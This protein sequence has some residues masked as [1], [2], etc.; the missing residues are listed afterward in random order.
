MEQR[1][2]YALPRY[3]A[4]TVTRQLVGHLYRYMPFAVDVHRLF[5]TERFRAHGQPQGIDLVAVARHARRAGRLFLV[6]DLMLLVCLAPFVA[7][8]V[9]GFMAFLT[10]DGAR[11]GRS[12]LLV[13]GALAAG[14]LVVF[15]WTWVMWRL[16]QAVQW[17]TTPPRDSAPAVGAVLEQELDALDDANVIVYS[18]EGPEGDQPF[19]GSGVSVLEKVWAGIDV[20]RPAED[21]AGEKLTAKEFTAQELHAHVAEHV[22]DIAGIDGLRAHNRLYVRGHHVR[23]LEAELLPDR[24][25]RPVTRIAPELVE[26]GVT[27]T[28]DVMRTYLTLELVGARGS[29][30]VTVHVRA[31]LVRS[32]LSWEVSAYYL[33]PVPAELSAK[34]T[35]PLDLGPHLL[36]VL[37]VTR[38]QLRNDLFGSVRRVLRRPLRR[39]ADAMGLL[40]RRYRISRP[41]SHFDYGAY[42]TLRAA[43]ATLQREWDYTQRM[44]ARDAIQRIQQA[45]L[46]ATEQFL[47]AHHIDTSDLRHAHK[48]INNQT[49]NFSGP[50]SGQNNFGNRGVNIVTGHRPGLGPARGPGAGPG[51]ALGSGTGSGTGTSPAPSGASGSTAK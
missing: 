8:L 31:R 35:R 20:A 27:E 37:D 6:R 25:R 40:W 10:K 50:I 16:A 38:G 11:L 43:A 42:G 17:G 45:L 12:L 33:P 39:L 30:V 7:G 22:A 3:T 47:T 15:T 23:D 49:Y 44:D 13:L 28:G 4:D 36:K 34:G 1:G 18:A 14:T 51:P 29:Y 48:T 9:D 21:D 41:R 19:L 2:K 24:L 26:E 46:H 32:R 5:V